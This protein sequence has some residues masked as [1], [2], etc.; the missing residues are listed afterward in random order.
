MKMVFLTAVLALAME[1]RR[2]VDYMTVEK[3]MNL[4]G[5]AY[6]LK[7]AKVAVEQV[8]VAPEAARIEVVVPVAARYYMQMLKIRR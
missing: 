6:R 1:V 3:V 4:M 7:K 5:K 8:A 2:V